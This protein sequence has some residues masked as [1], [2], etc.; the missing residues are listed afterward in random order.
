MRTV[1]HSGIRTCCQYIILICKHLCTY[2]LIPSHQKGGGHKQGPNLF[3]LFGRVAG[4][5]PPG[6]EG[7]FAYSKANMSSGIT[8]GEQEL[9]DYLLKPSKYIPVSWLWL[10]LQSLFLLVFP[11]TDA[12][13]MCPLLCTHWLTQKTKMVFAGLK[14]K[15]D[16]INLIGYLKKNT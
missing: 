2:L 4:V 11:I 7:S 6:R 12:T 9:F 3:G 1:P 14:K 13:C 15:G 16:R 10:Y 8:W 5:G